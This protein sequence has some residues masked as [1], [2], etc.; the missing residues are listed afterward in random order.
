MNLAQIL[1]GGQGFGKG[2]GFGQAIQAASPL[3]LSMASGMQSGNPYQHMG[4]GILAMQL[5]QAQRQ[6]EEERKRQEEAARAGQQ[7]AAG[8]LSNIFG[9]PQIGGAPGGFTGA[10]GMS[11][12]QTTQLP[13]GD[14]GGQPF[15]IQPT[16]GRQQP[17]L[18]E[19]FAMT[20]QQYGL[21]QGYLQRTAQIESSMNPGAQ[22]PNSSAKGLFQFIDSTA[23]QYGVNP[24]DPASSTDGAARL[25]ADNARVLRQALGREPTAAELYLAH[26][27]GAGGAA[28]LLSNPNAR[29]VDIVGADAVRL[30]GG[31]ENMTAGQ[32]AQKWTGK[33]GGQQQQPQI[34]PQRG[35]Q[36][37]QSPYVS[38]EV[39]KLVLAQMQAQMQPQEPD[40]SRYK[41]VGNQ[42]VDL[43][44]EGGPAMIPGVSGASPQPPG[45]SITLPDGTAINQGMPSTPPGQNPLTTATPRDPATMGRKMSEGDAGYLQAER[46]RARTA[47]DLSG[48]ATRLETL[49]PDVG[50]TG[51]GG[52]AYGLVDSILMD[53][54]PGSS[55]ARGAFNS[56]ATEAQL[57]F[58]ERTKGAITEQE[59]ALFK[60]AVPGLGQTPEANREI[61]RMLKAG[62]E[63]TRTRARFMEAYA[64]R[65]GTLQGA[66]DAWNAYMQENPIIT[67][68]GEAVKVAPEGNWSS[69]LDRPQSI[70]MT[71]QSIM[72]MTPDDLATIPLEKMTEDQR[73]AYRARLMQLGG[74]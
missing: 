45:F 57:T 58:T 9:Q 15:Q 34:D 39:K 71:P 42:M 23:Q 20:E 64:G 5:Q 2:S 53:A 1:S 38:D 37:L 65:R 50:Y 25:A 32:F 47:E 60:K 30:N 24:M 46:E 68:D 67:R 17:Q 21:P 22:N 29:A 18:P 49:Q 41:V 35:M 12:P 51:P 3:L 26:Q 19:L 43:G 4:Q 7:Q 13:V 62:A 61:A 72:Q 55:G 14:A 36:I 66:E 40:Y 16:G 73:R 48:L 10:G 59:M 69:Y 70:D 54:L 74:Q 8:M 6:E 44:A 31:N 28:K 11:M 63:R 52:Q 27:Q 33:F 56:A